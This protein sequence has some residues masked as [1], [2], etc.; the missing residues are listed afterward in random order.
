MEKAARARDVSAV[1]ARMAD[2]DAQFEALKDAM[3]KDMS[4]LRGT[5]TPRD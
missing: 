5:Q 4:S 3:Q 1:K 2:L